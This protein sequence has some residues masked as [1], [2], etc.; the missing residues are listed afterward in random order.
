MLG[1]GTKNLGIDL[2]TANTI[3]YLEGKGIVLREPSVV[4]RNAKTNEVI[5]VGS[6][7]RDMIGR[8]PESIV[9]IRPM[10]DGV[11]ADYDT[12]VAM[13]KYYIDK[14]LGNNGKPYVM[15]CVPSGITEVE[16]RAVIDATRVAGARDAYV[17]EEPFAAAIGAGLPVMDPTGSMVVDIGGGTTDV[18]TISL[19]G[20]VSSRSIR[21]AGDKMN[22][23]IVQ[24]VRQ[25]MNLLIGERTAE[26]LKWD[27][28]SASVEAAEEMGTTQV[29]GR[30]LVTGLPKTMQVSATDVSTA[31]QDVVDSI[32]TAIKGTLE[33]TSP[34]IAADVIDHGIVLTGGGAL[35]KHLPD[36]IA[37]AT[38]VP[39]FIANDP[40][41]CV[42]IGTGE[43]LKS[44]DVMKKK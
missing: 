27:I 38:K 10:K 15:V 9:A 23:A 34:E 30:D 42:A 29:R 19:G 41:D 40:L 25:N 4:A 26:K 35:L 1:I 12:T 5:S 6:D 22:D 37:D 3:V 28:G 8:T 16:K 11:I 32:I 13:M 20:I 2:G 33:E 31:L 36:V 14:T 44:I 24:Y 39:V 18:A 17:I 7:A 43:S 21:M